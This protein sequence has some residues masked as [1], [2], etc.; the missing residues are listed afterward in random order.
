MRSDKPWKIVQDDIT[1][2]LCSRHDEYFTVE[3]FTVDKRNKTGLSQMCRECQ[4]LKRLEHKDPVYDPTGISDSILKN[5]GYILD[6][7]LTVHE[8]FLLKHKLKK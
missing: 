7:E 2:Y 4:R 5:L 8:Q 6:G 1:L 3:H